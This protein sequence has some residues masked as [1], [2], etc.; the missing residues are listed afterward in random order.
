MTQSAP[1]LQ[2]HIPQIQRDRAA[3]RLPS[4]VPVAPGDWL[5]VDDA[6]AGQ[7]AEKARLIAAHRDRVM[8][9]LP[10]ARDAAAELLTVV[11]AEIAM[12]P[13][14]AMVG[15]GIRRPDGVVVSPDPKDPLLTLSQLVQEDLCIL[16]KQGDEHVLTAAL[17]CFPA[18]WTLA[19]KIGRPLTVIHVPVAPYDDG[20]AAR[21]QRLFDGVQPGRPVWRANLLR[22]EDPTLFQPRAEADQRPVG[23]PDSAFERSE[24]QTV[25]RLPGTRAVVFSIHTH[26]VRRGA[27]SQG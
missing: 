21:V 13:D 7:L 3:A 2:S 25:L 14:F 18:S 10:E 19:E 22:Y 16:Q 6:Y 26:V 23:R 8:A 12:R 1:I 20:I 5:Q 9:C 24:R 17:L 4:M 27:I 11:L 15:H